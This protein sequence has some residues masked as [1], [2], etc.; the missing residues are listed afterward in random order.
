MKLW[1]TLMMF[2]VC[3]SGYGADIFPVIRTGLLPPQRSENRAFQGIAG[4]EQSAGGRLWAAWYGGRQQ[5][6]EDDDVYLA[7]SGD[8]GQTW[9][10]P[11]LAVDAPEPV[12]CFDEVLWRDPS[13]R[14]WLFWAQAVMYQRNPWVWAMVAETPDQPDAG[15]S[16]P[17]KVAPGIMMNK[18][19]VLS[20]GEW[21]LPVAPAGRASAEVWASRDQGRSFEYRGGAFVPP[22]ARAPLE[23]MV[24][25]RS[26]GRLWMTVRA[27]YGIAE[28]F[29]SDGGKT[30]SDAEPSALLHPSARFYIRRLNS[31]NLLLVKHG[32]L[33]EQTDRSRLTAYLS[34]DDGCTWIG[35]LM[36]DERSGISYPDGCQSA[37]GIV[38]VIYDYQRNTEKEILLASFTEEDVRA[39]TVVSDEAAFQIPVNKAFG[40]PVWVPE[41]MSELRERFEVETEVSG[42]PPNNAPG[43]AMQWSEGSEL[44]AR[45]GMTVWFPDREYRIVEWPDR[46]ADMALIRSG[47]G[48]ASGVCQASGL[49][50]VVTPLPERHPD[51]ASDELLSQ[52]FQPLNE[53]EF[54]LFYGS[55]YVSRIYWKKLEA[56]EP[57]DLGPW[58][59]VLLPPGTPEPVALFE[60]NFSRAPVLS[61]FSGCRVKTPCFCVYS[62][63]VVIKLQKI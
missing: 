37:D 25:E 21:V 27:R 3:G 14:I 57:I 18:P 32:P 56:G 45:R 19:T 33:D 6:S 61:F 26:D 24:V 28:S 22:D 2:M 60:E 5:E 35:G 4:I 59:L 51:S 34:D 39:G 16:R 52:G 41:K 23:H 13:G 42:V 40:L 62:N 17:F 15:W 20:S 63:E 11:V 53:P 44:D 58:A 55:E 30:W 1:I 54:I 48:R 50:Y 46:L 29:S 43:A 49:L 38:Y 9:S 36:L 8:G 7:T 10:D 47:T 12:R 31:G